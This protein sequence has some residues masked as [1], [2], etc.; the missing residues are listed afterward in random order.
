MFSVL[1]PGQGSQS[2]GMGK[3]LYEKYDYIKSLF[4][5]ADDILKKSLSKIILEGPKD[6]IN[7]TENTQPA[8]FLVSYSIFEVIKKETSFDLNKAKFFA[9]HSLGEYSALACSGSLNF[10]QTIKLLQSRGRFMQSAVPKGQ[11]GMLAVLGSDVEKINDIINKNI[12]NFKCY[13][14]NDNSIG[15]VVVSGNISDLDKFSAELKINKIKNI[16]LPVSAPFHCELMRSATEKMRQEITKE[17][18]KKPEINIISNV[19]AQQTNNPN[20]IKNLLI[21]QIEKPVRWREIVINMIDSK[22]DKFI[23]IGPGKVLSGLVKRINSNVNLIQVN[24]LEDL[25]NLKW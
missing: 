13:V 17:E 3:N 23:E 1:F 19:T 10:T 9:G 12:E 2:V 25:N 15:Q 8:I 18:F 20:E 4:E 6:L 14:A 11:G 21:E 24:D 22:V 16:K 5:Q 7:Q